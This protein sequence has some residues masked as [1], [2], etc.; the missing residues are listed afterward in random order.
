V[1]EATDLDDVGGLI[2]PP[3]PRCDNP[4]QLG[5][6]TTMMLK[7]Q[8]NRP[9]V[10][11]K[12]PLPGYG[13][14]VIWEWL[15]T[16][17]ARWTSVCDLEPRRILSPAEATPAD[18]VNY[19]TVA[20]LGGGGVLADQQLPFPGGTVLRMRINSVIKWVPTDGPMQ[21]GIDPVRTLC[22]EIG[23]FLGFQHYPTSDPRD[24][25]EPTIHNNVVGPQT[26]ESKVA[27]GWFGP[28]KP[29]TP[30]PT[31]PGGGA[32]DILVKFERPILVREVLFKRVS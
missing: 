10:Y 19:V 27:V 17:Y 6:G 32:D 23:H 20:N 28:P 3:L 24:L 31:V 5:D 9:L 2:V 4:E 7:L 8:T 16:A 21:G 26:S 29:T 14:D 13:V 11:V 25:M 12:D 15:R 30:G 18:V 22:H 1:A